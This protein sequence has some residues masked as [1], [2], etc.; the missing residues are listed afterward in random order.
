M[1]DLLRQS[2]RLLYW[3]E[4]FHF[5][6]DMACT[7]LELTS[8]PVFRFSEEYFY[9]IYKNPINSNEPLEEALANA[10]TYEKFW[11]KYPGT[12]KAIRKFMDHQ[13]NGYSA[14]SDYLRSKFK[15]GVR[16]LAT[17]ITRTH[18]QVNPID[19]LEILFDYHRKFLK[20]CP[21]P[22][23]I[24]KTLKA[25][26][27]RIKFV[28]SQ[29]PEKL[30]IK[31]KKFLKDVKKLSSEIIKKL[32]RAIGQLS[33]NLNLNGLGFKPLK[34]CDSVFR[35]RLDRNFRVTLRPAGGKWELLRVGKHEYVDRNPI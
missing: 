5:V 23:Y 24:V 6:T 22:I 9:K 30:L 33:I 32:D 18:P 11:R 26:K 28:H 16:E 25:D 15:P 19:S 1:I 8:S 2:F 13:P 34:S 20:Y 7:V 10:Y 21:V 14:Y 31:S 29:I 12:T 27:Y 3:H 4:Y 35:F 17:I